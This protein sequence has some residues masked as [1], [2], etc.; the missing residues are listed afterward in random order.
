LV[1]L[2][3]RIQAHR[4]LLNDAVSVEVV[5]EIPSVQESG[6][7]LDKCDLLSLKLQRGKRKKS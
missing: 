2:A 1:Y 7:Q 6:F 3:E 5:N 4:H